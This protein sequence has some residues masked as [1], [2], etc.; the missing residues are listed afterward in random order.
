MNVRVSIRTLRAVALGLCLAVALC[1][2]HAPRAS[3]SNDCEGDACSHVIVTYDDSKQQY[4]A[5]NNSTD[6]WVRV[7]ASNLAAATSACIEP[8]KSAYL[9]LKSLV[10]PYRTTYAEARFGEQ[11]VGR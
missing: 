6:R 5:Q 9:P 4:Q 7:S 3:A 10:M 2:R 8:G 1:L 11:G